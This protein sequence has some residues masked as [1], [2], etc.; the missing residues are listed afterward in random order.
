M[1]T[2]DEY[3]LTEAREKSMKDQ[4]L[5]TGLEKY[6]SDG[7]RQLT[8]HSESIKTFTGLSKKYVSELQVKKLAPLMSSPNVDNLMKFLFTLVYLKPES[9]YNPKAFEK[10]A[11]GDDCADFQAKLAS[12]KT[13]RFH[14]EPETLR[15]F[16][17]LKELEYP[18]S[19]KNKDLHHLLSWMDYTYEIYLEEVQYSK[20]LI[21][22][23]RKRREK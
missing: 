20:P 22:G 23:T 3:S 21:S 6:S 9:E 13:I 2:V 10:I 11:L 18:E 15:K 7:G 4:N 14:D 12:F 8:Q 5:K 16:A 17:N 1:V 19:Q